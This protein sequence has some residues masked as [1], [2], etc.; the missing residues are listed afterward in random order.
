M[1]KKKSMDQ[2]PVLGNL[3][4][5]KEIDVVN[6]MIR[7]IQ[8]PTCITFFDAAVLPACIIRSIF[9]I[10]KKDETL[11]KVVVVHKT[12]SS[13]LFKIGLEHSSDENIGKR[14]KHKL[15]AILFL[16]KIQEYMM[17][18]I[19]DE[20]R[21]EPLYLFNLSLDIKVDSSKNNSI[22]QT[23]NSE[24]IT[25]KGIVYGLSEAKLEFKD[26]TPFIYPLSKNSSSNTTM[27]TLETLCQQYGS[28]LAIIYD[29]KLSGQDLLLIKNKFSKENVLLNVN[30]DPDTNRVQID[31]RE[32]SMPA[33]ECS[34]FISRKAGTQI[35]AIDSVVLYTF[36]RDV[37]AV[38]GYDYHNY[39][40]NS[41]KR[42][43]QKKMD[44]QGI[45]SFRHFAQNILGC[46][47]Q[48]EELFL[49]LSVNVT[50]FF[51]N[52]SVFEKVRNE[53]I[54]YLE[55]FPH[56]KIW[57]AGCSTGEE[58]YSLAM[59]FKEMGLLHKIQIYA[60]DI[61]PLVI[62]QAKNGIFKTDAIERNKFSHHASGGQ[63]EFIDHFD[64]QGEISIVK[65]DIR[66]SILFFQH[67]LV[68]EGILNEFHLILCRNVLIY[69]N[70]D[71][72]QQVCSLFKKSLIPNGFLVL[73]ESEIGLQVPGLEFVQKKSGILKNYK[74]AV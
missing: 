30:S 31:P 32:M 35:P 14:I 60:T 50:E 42:L 73:G 19:E 18:D 3:K 7:S 71:L 10:Q 68:N 53:I 17:L 54:P 74:T 38:Y 5:A 55:S 48:F 52:P 16:G 64:N 39:A 21:S 25:E 4:S 67:S 72:Q 45:S 49:E 8:T 41:L 69:F 37:T 20:I 23:V 47:E 22:Y 70:S 44:L 43:I 51:R 13:Y 6:N 65:K 62:Q 24:T 11:I 34:S 27:D 36:L 58:P 61:N 26:S 66:E 33:Q 46:K 28:E 29:S 57:C 59:M 2:I 9:S 40:E 15:K 12:L 56:I 1:I 63:G